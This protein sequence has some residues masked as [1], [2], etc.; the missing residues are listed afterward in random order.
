MILVGDPNLSKHQGDMIKRL[1]EEDILQIPVKL[2]TKH[3]ELLGRIWTVR[4]D[5]PRWIARLKESREYSC[6]G[7]AIAPENC[8]A[9]PKGSITIDNEK[10][11]RY[12]GEIQVIKEDL[13]ACEKVN[14]I[15]EV[16]TEYLGLVELLT[17][18]RKF[19]FVI[20]I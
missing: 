18:G 6:F 11:L 13:P 15:G 12:S 20:K 10:Y 5:S 1:E 3:E 16:E 17:R 4:E 9:R 14:V 2:D 19:E 8:G 7:K